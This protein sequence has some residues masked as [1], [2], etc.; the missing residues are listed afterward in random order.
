[1]EYPHAAL[2]A[3]QRD[4]LFAEFH[5]ILPGSS[6][7][8]VEEMSL[9]LMNH[10]LEELSRVKAR[11]FFRMA[12]GQP[13]APD[14]QIPIL[15]YNPHPFPVR[16]VFECE[17]QLH[18]QN[19]SGSFVDV[20]VRQGARA[21]PTQVEKEASN[22]ALDWRKRVVFAATLAPSQIT[23]FDCVLTHLKAKP[24][25]QLKARGKNF[26]FKNDR[27]E[28][29][30][31]R[32][33]GALDQYRIDG[34]DYLGKGGVEATVFEDNEDSWGMRVTS[35]PKELGRF[36]LLSKKAGTRFSGVTRGAIDSVRVIEDGPVRVVIEAVF[37]Y[38]E[39]RLVLHYELPTQGTQIALGVRVVWA[40][41]DRMLKLALATGWKKSRYLGQVAYGVQEL[42]INREEAV[43]Q[44][45][46]S[47]VD[48]KSGAA[49]TC[50]N[51]GVYGSSFDRG[52]I[53]LSLLR[54]P[55]YS[56]H[57]IPDLRATDQ[58]LQVGAVAKGEQVF[59]P[60]V[61]QDRF[62]PRMDQGERLYRFW[63]DGGDAKDRLNLIDREALAV[64]EKPF[65]LSF[66]PPGTGR[67]PAAGVSL[68][69]N[70]VQMSA[71]KIS[72][73]GTSLIVR[74]FEPTGRVRTTTLKIPA[75]SI[76]QSIKLG[77]FEIK[78]LGI[79]LQT[80]TLREMNLVEEFP[81]TT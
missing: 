66:F 81:V 37:A 50:I 27:I 72:D 11:A 38:E 35:F 56:G 29:V 53:F 70:V 62:S 7:Q 80:R 14:G 52:T 3:A 75:L 36:K 44:K 54:S 78:T 15:A 68:G 21:L 47:A 58:A 2:K 8:P 67:T 49:L 6:I 28:V 13:A 71:C 76:K 60:I 24:P 69:D 63:L 12:A 41:K 59:F 25:V 74:L 48:D 4:L 65:V 45:W 79:N 22:L 40:E 46:V 9:R 42:P 32:E 64:N 43:A 34:R 1:M 55:S 18:D 33:T 26:V 5:D 73:D 17:F 77:A 30:I 16:G 51:D 57:P 23:R 61:P 31:N 19:W 39:S 20:S 10:A